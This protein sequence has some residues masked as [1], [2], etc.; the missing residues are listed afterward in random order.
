ME[1]SVFD[2]IRILLKKWYVILLVMVLLGGAAGVL[3][4]KS[5]QTALAEYEDY[6]ARELPVNTETGDLTA[7]FP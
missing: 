5:Y 6:T 3:S 7:A 1:Y 2:L 4:Q